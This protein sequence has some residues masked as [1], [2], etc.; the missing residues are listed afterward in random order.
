MM[1]EQVGYLDWDMLMNFHRIIYKIE[2]ELTT[3]LGNE[4]VISHPEGNCTVTVE[5]GGKVE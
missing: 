4:C 2:W 1:V 5:A 3:S